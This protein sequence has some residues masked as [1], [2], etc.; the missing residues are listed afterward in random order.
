MADLNKPITTDAYTAV[1]A[2]VVENTDALAQGLDPA[3]VTVTNPPTGAIRW[4]SASSKWEK[5]DGTSWADL[6]A[7]YAINISGS[8]DKW[9]TGRTITFT[10]AATGISDAFDGSA[11]ISISLTLATV[12]AAKGGTGQ[13]SYT[14]GDILYASG[15]AALSKLAGVGTGYA[16]IS[17][18]VGAAPSWGK[19]ALTTHVSGALPVANGGTGATDAAGARAALGVDAGMD[20]GTRMVFNQSTPPTGWTKDTTAGLND[21]ALRIVT[22]T[23]GAGGSEAFTTAFS[24]VVAGSV[25]SGGGGTSGATTITTAMMPSHKHD[26]AI[27]YSVGNRTAAPGIAAPSAGY[28]T[29]IGYANSAGA[30][31]EGGGGSHTHTTPNH[32]HTFTGTTNLAVKYVDFIIASKD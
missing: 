32:T 3:V 22:G 31:P 21:S 12:A 29:S 5:F 1:L 4:R 30:N 24:G 25:N 27:T 10:G 23:V 15:A 28:Q 6:A 2:S 16:L 20:V 11:N 8:A 18:G 13:T 17:G 26:Y 7:T 14:V 19:I 9:A